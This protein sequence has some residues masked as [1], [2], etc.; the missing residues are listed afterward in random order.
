M[1]VQ[2]RAED[3]DLV[4]KRKVQDRQGGIAL[5]AGR[6]EEGTGEIGGQADGEGVNRAA[7]DEF[8]RPV[9]HDQKA[10]EQADQQTD[11]QR[12]R[13][14]GKGGLS[15]EGAEDGEKRAHQDHAVHAD[16]HNACVLGHGAA[17]GSQGDRGRAAEHLLE[18]TDGEDGRQ[19]F[20]KFRHGLPPPFRIST[21]TFSFAGAREADPGSRPA[22]P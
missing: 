19:R 22:P 11:A 21:G 8:I 9:A 10:E 7:Y 17:D 1:V 12:Q 18:R 2:H 3:R 16:V 14:A 4:Q 15:Q 5:R 13:N 6:T 20:F